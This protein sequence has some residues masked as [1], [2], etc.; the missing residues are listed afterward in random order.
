MTEDERHLL[1]AC[2]GAIGMLVDHARRG[3]GIQEY[4]WLES[5]VQGEIVPAFE[6]VFGPK[7]TQETRAHPP[8]SC[9]IGGDCKHVCSFCRLVPCICVSAPNRMAGK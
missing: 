4:E 6:R 2:C 1:K 3:A 7:P 8:G 9:L 5:M